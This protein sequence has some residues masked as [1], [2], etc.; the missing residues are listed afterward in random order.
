MIERDLRRYVGSAAA[1]NSSNYVQHTRQM[2]EKQEK[3]SLGLCCDP[4]IDVQ[5]TKKLSSERVV[6]IYVYDVL[7][8]MSCYRAR[9]GHEVAKTFI[10]MALS[11]S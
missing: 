5:V 9:R 1:S 8:N 11:V 10:P 3:I 6:D 7:Q 4:V 2:N